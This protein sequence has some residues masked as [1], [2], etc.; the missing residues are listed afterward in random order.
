MNRGPASFPHVVRTMPSGLSVGLWALV[1]Q[2]VMSLRCCGLG[3]V[4]GLGVSGLGVGV[5]VFKVTC[6]CRYII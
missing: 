1:V 3:G 5:L 4:S 6:I 2:E